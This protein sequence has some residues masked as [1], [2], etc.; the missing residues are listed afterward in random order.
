MKIIIGVTGLSG[1]GKD[2]FASCLA[3]INPSQHEQGSP[4]SMKMCYNERKQPTRR[5]QTNWCHEPDPKSDL[6]V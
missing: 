5:S 3:L 6:D 2:E 1:A 4:L